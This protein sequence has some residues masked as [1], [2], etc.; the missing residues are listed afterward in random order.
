[1]TTI[2]NFSLFTLDM[3]SHT[4]FSYL[5]QKRGN[6]YQNAYLIADKSGSSAET[7]PFLSACV[8]LH[9][10]FHRHWKQ[11]KKVATSC[12]GH[13]QNANP[14]AC[15]LKIRSP[16]PRVQSLY[17]CVRQ[18]EFGQHECRGDAAVCPWASATVAPSGASSAASTGFVHL[19][20][21][22]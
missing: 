16:L 3:Q 15:T 5:L 13:V 22:L 21:P 11:Q 6:K 18:D 7:Q 8:L 2:G 12:G 1:V 10:F 14:R 20:Q 17:Y 19:R 4:T 9:C